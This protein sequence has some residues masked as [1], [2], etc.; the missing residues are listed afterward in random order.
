MND[1]IWNLYLLQIIRSKGNVMYLIDKD[2]T[3]PNIL[4]QINKLSVQ[5][6]VSKEEHEYKLTESGEYYFKDMCRKLK[7]RGIYRYFMESVDKK[8]DKISPEEI[9]IP[10]KRF[11]Q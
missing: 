2:H 6:Y 4:K 11:K 7:K 3:I 5:G 10:R 1:N 9:Y 8:T